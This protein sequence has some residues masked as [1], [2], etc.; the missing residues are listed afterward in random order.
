MKLG[1]TPAHAAETDVSPN[2]SAANA[3][4][5]VNLIMI[6]PPLKTWATPPVPLGFYRTTEPYPM[7]VRPSHG[8]HVGGRSSIS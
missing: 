6:R 3:R 2:V 7:S 1:V 5:T 4:K 8:C